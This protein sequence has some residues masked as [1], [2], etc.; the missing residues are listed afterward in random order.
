ML[1]RLAGAGNEYIERR[2]HFE[3]VCEERMLAFE[4]EV[5]RVYGVTV[6]FLGNATCWQGSWGQRGE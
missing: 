4:L 3:C 1:A 6:K 2:R 5:K